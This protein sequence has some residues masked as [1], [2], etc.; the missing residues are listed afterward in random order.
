MRGLFT[1]LLLE[2][3]GSTM[4]DLEANTR[5]VLASSMYKV[6]P[7]NYRFENVVA[8]YNPRFKYV[9]FD[10][11][12]FN[13]DTRKHYK[14]A[15]FFYNVAGDSPEDAPDLA[16]NPVRVA[17]SCPAY[18][19]YFSYWN[20]MGGAHARRPLR[21][22]VRK[23]PPPPEGLPFKNPDHLPGAC[24]HILAFANYLHEADYQL[25]DSGVTKTAANQRLKQ[26]ADPAEQPDN[27]APKRLNIQ[28]LD[29]PEG[30][31]NG[32]PQAGQ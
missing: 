9:S 8:N 23:T 20:K 4:M 11:T 13:K 26:N 15:I 10:C 22:Y 6:E 2:A 25:G 1:G 24:K 29:E 14:T 30:P 17:C 32:D 7:Y 21:G 19:F 12:T 3:T 31:N 16:K 5:K 18:Y 27:T 28:T